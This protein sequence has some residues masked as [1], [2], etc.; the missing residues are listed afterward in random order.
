MTGPGAAAA[1]RVAGMLVT[2]S[3]VKDTLENV[4]FFVEANHSSGVDHLVV[5]LDAPRDPG[6]PEVA[7]WLDAHPAVT[8]LRTG[9][10]WWGGDR[11]RSLNVRQQVNVNWLRAALEPLGWAQWLVH[12][13]GDEVARVDAGAVASVP[14]D[15]DALWLPPLEAVSEPE[16]AARPTRFKRLLD[17]DDLALLQVLGAVAEPTNQAYFH[18]H[19]MGKSAVRPASGLALSLH[20]ALAPTGERVPRH[21]DERLAVLHY[22]A[23]SG[24][25]FVRK[26]TA[27]AHAG[28]ARYR[29]SRAPVARA[30]AALVGKDLPDDV[31]ARYL[32]RVY[33]RT[34]RDDVGLLADL[35]LLVEVDPLPGG[36]AG[37]A[38]RPLPPEAAAGLADRVEELRDRPKRPYLVE[39]RRGA[40]ATTPA[41]D[42]A[43][44]SGVR[45]LLRHGRAG[46]AAR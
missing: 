26:W 31:R 43:G 36:A 38:P 32:R 42:G 19:V 13:D 23:V 6:Q 10:S 39:E 27:L 7:A 18:G 45:G 24:A 9:R 16:P 11:P 41:H 2:A 3:T 22:D 21:E 5:F 4:R 40:A 17:E 28:P 20:H 46:G 14:A 37:A 35:G 34:T 30:L 29:A 1:T 15:R 44:R 25:E 8:C 33:D 12:L